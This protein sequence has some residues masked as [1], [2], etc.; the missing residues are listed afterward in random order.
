M[1][2]NRIKILDPHCVNQIAAG[3]VVER[4]LS[5]VKELIENS[6]DASAGKIEISVEG[7]GTP[8]IKVKDDGTGI[9]SGE[10]G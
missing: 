7:G 10:L 6:L 1:T 5:V 2:L 4:P 8:F 3:E 9:L